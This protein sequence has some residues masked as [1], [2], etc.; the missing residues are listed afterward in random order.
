MSFDTRLVDD[1]HG[2]LTDEIVSHAVFDKVSEDTDDALESLL[3][4]NA[5]FELN[6]KYSAI[7][8]DTPIEWFGITALLAIWLKRG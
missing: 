8:H 7:L 4:V 1:L 5:G 3:R 6:P 2:F